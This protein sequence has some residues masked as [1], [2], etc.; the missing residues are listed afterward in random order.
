[1]EH[2]MV[3]SGVR[4]M[5][6]S[7]ACRHIP[8][9]GM[10]PYMSPYMACRHIPGRGMARVLIQPGAWGHMPGAGGGV[11]CGVVCRWMGTMPPL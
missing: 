10:S 7:G 5:Q 1:M 2:V 3:S 8:E 11:W 6:A 9:R 4:G